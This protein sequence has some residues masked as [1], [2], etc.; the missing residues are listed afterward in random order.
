M[1][2]LY[3]V[4]HA[5]SLHQAQ[6][7]TGGWYDT[8]LTDLG[9]RQAEKIA[10][11]LQSRIGDAPIALY[12]SDL[13]RAIETAEVIAKRFDADPLLMPQ[14]RELCHGEGDGRP[15]QW[16]QKRRSPQPADGGSLDYRICPGAETLAECAERVYAGMRSIQS[17]DIPNLIVVSH[18]LVL[19]YMV[20]AWLKVPIMGLSDSRLVV[21]PGSLTL[22]MEDESGQRTLVYLNR[23]DHLIH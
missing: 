5:E 19:T 3:L 20:L 22:L 6:G 18:S 17:V 15:R 2:H 9:R 21:S 4:T 11:E 1:R 12:S 14:I 16:L 8:G 23:T 7:L 10:E 13:R